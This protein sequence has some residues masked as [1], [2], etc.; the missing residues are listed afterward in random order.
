MK[1]VSKKIKLTTEV[2]ANK[3]IEISNSKRKSFNRIGLYYTII[4]IILFFAFFFLAIYVQKEPNTK[5]LEPT[6]KK[7]YW[8]LLARKSNIEYLYKG[9]AGQEKESELVR[10]FK[11]KSGI[12]RQRPTPLPQLIGREYWVMTNKFETTQNP[13]TAPYFIELD[14]PWGLEYPFGPIPYDECN[15]QCNWTL[16]GPF[17]LHGVSGDESR[18]SDENIGSSG[19]I[20]HTDED[21]TYLYKL[22]DMNDDIRYYIRDI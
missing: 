1:K 20:R 7:G 14:V 6:E 16:P 19:C 11:V 21:I 3:G 22:L 5:V 9:V 4:S 12:P 2:A 18:L 10:T 8:L 15:G 17:G 13:E